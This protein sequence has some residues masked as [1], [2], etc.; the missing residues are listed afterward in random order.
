MSDTVLR[1]PNV[2]AEAP[3]NYS[4]LRTNWPAIWAGLFVFAAIWIVFEMLGKAI[5]YNYG[6]VWGL[7]TWTIILSI[8]AMY[9]AGLET[10]RLSGAATRHEGLIHGLIMWGLSMVGLTIVLA[11][12]GAATSAGVAAATANPNLVVPGRIGVLNFLGPGAEWAEWL[13]LFLSWGAA[14]MGG[15]VG[16]TRFAA[17]IRRPQQPPVPMR[18]AA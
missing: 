16:A 8:I 3:A 2:Y 5:F 18:P 14:M 12:I 10:G 7:G 6:G 17:Q 1:T 15:S 13:A 9:V 11:L 4:G